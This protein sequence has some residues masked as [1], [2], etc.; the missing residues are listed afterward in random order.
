MIEPNMNLLL[1]AILIMYGVKGILSLFA[2]ILGANK[3]T[4]YGVA[5]VVCGILSL[6]LVVCVIA[7]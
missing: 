7:L 1:W 2:G 5:D 3:E 6:A 4:K